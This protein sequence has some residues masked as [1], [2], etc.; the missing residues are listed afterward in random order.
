MTDKQTTQQTEK[1]I[2]HMHGAR[3]YL[4]SRVTERETDA[5]IREAIQSPSASSYIFKVQDYTWE[6]QS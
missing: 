5:D 3:F 2:R 1:R 4:V 6:V